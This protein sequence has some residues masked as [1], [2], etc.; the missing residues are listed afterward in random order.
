M[1][2]RLRIYQKS[3]LQIDSSSQEELHGD[4]KRVKRIK[5][6]EPLKNDDAENVDGAQSMCVEQF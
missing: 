5:Y 4:P 2:V 1:F 6:N 3:L